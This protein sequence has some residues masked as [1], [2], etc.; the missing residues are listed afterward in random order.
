MP[1]FNPGLVT[2]YEQIT[3]LINTDSIV[4]LNGTLV[5]MGSSTGLQ[6]PP[7]D[8]LQNVYKLYFS[9]ETFI[10]LDLGD[11]NALLEFRK[12]SVD[13]ST[14]R[15][16][17]HV[18][19]TPAT[20]AFCLPLRSGN[21]FTEWLEM[22]KLKF[23][24]EGLSE[25]K[26]ADNGVSQALIEEFKTFISGDSDVVPLGTPSGLRVSFNNDGGLFKQFVIIAH[27]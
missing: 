10:C 23:F 18:K 20:K 15:E 5:K 13:F 12:G 22:D 6:P 25:T 27:I 9:L 16:T 3:D 17:T 14:G 1:Q 26:L 19:M 11:S 4:Q 24:L 21:G 8:N 7:S 2:I